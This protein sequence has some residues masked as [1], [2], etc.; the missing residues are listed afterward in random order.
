MNIQADLFAGLNQRWRE[1]RESYRV[2]DEP[3]RTLEHEVAVLE[4]DTTP[5]AFVERHHYEG[6]YPA[7][8]FR[9]GLFHGGE[10]V[11]V[12]VFSHP[13]RDEVLTS[14]FPGEAT[15][16]VELGRFVLLDSVAGNG[17]TWFLARAFDVLR[18]EGLRGI[19]SFSDPMKRTTLEGAETCPGHVGTIY[20]A[21]NGVYLG[22][23]PST[24]GRGSRSRR[25]G[26]STSA[27]GGGASSASGSEPSSAS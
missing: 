10:L 4:D 2:P 7:A 9:F 5:R 11:G 3:I 16:S 17:E 18:R 26:A 8:R 12:A 25:S 22:R 15:D 19:V 1:G 13:M 24:S 21:A 6:S 27:P 14:V 23:A 20:Q